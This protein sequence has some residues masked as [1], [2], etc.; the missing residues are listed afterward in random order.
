MEHVHKPGD[1]LPRG[2]LREWIFHCEFHDLARGTNHDL[3]FERKFARNCGAQRRLAHIL[4]HN[5]RAD[6]ADVDHAELCQLFCDYCRLASIRCP[7]VHCAKKN[8]PLHK[9]IVDG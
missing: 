9:L 4:A 2:L 1:A 8:N 6:G 5:K 3:A 7:D